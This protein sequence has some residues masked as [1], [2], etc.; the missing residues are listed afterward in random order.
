M[1]HEDSLL[2]IYD[3]YPHKQARRKALLEIERA[4]GRLMKIEEGP[5]TFEEAV[6]G[7][8]Q[9]VGVFSKSP[10]GQCNGL[11]DGYYPPHP[12]TW[13]HQ[14]RYLDSPEV[15]FNAAKKESSATLRGRETSSA[16]DRAFEIENVPGNGLS[17]F[18]DNSERRRRQS[19]ERDARPRL[20][21]G[22]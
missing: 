21:F 10:A 18:Q 13:F 11:F 8:M 17:I 12:A 6:K 5:M 15:W 4:V 22:D 20:N 19:L 3:L 1:S 9:A 16:L 7:L 14:S 2:A